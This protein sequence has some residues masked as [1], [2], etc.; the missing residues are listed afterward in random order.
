MTSPIS[1]SP[2]PPPCFSSLTFLLLSFPPAP[3]QLISS[4]C[5]L[6]IIFFFLPTLSFF[7]SSA[8]FLYYS[9]HIITFYLLLFPSSF[10]L[11]VL[12]VFLSHSLY[13]LSLFT[14]SQSFT[15]FLHFYQQWPSVWL[16]SPKRYGLPS[17]IYF[18]SPFSF[19]LVNPF[20]LSLNFSFIIFLRTL[21]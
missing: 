3:L 7:S 11:S 4:L 20:V 16:S 5:L 8:S 9:L 10:P 14:Y 1:F 17:V 15:L 6:S 19:I 13:S 21:P 18:V 2:L 12:L